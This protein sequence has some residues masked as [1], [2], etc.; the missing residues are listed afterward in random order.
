MIQVLFVCLGNICRSPITEGIFK[1]LVREKGL[2]AIIQCDSAGTAAYH[3]GSLADKRM[4]K[5]ALAQGIILTHCARQFSDK[6]FNDYN[7]ILAMD[8]SNYEHIRKKGLR[9]DGSYLPEQQLYLYRMFDPKRGS[10]VNVPDPYYEEI[11]AFEEVCEIVKRS[12]IAFLDFIIK[13]H[14]LTI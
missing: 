4:R 8:Q 6:D 11:A 5:V 12:G 1:D 3:I 14:N 2:E 9:G 13:K 10:S 7:Y